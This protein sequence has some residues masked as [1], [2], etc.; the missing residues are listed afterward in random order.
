MGLKERIDALE[1]DVL[2]ESAPK[3]SLYPLFKTA[4]LITGK[5]GLLPQSTINNFYLTTYN[6][7]VDTPLRIDPQSVDMTRLE[8]NNT[9]NLRCPMCDTQSSIRK[10]IN[11]T[12][13]HLDKIIRM[14]RDR[15]PGVQKIFSFHTVGEPI[16]S[17]MFEDYLKILDRYNQKL[18]LSTNGI[19]IDRKLDLLCKYSHLIDTIR[20]SIDGATKETYERMRWP[21]KFPKLIENLELFTK[22]NKGNKYFKKVKIGSVICKTTKDEIAHHLD[23]YQKYVP[24]KNIKFSFLTS[25]SPTKEF[26][27]DDVILEKHIRLN[28]PC[29]AIFGSEHHVLANGDVSPCSRDYNGEITV[30]NVF[31]EDFDSIVNS[32]RSVKLREEQLAGGALE[33]SLC[34]TC[35]EIDG[36]IP[37]LFDYL[38]HAI[39]LQ[40]SYN[41][42]SVSRAQEKF[43]RFLEICEKGFPTSNEYVTLFD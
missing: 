26:F 7:K 29:S 21:A 33:G 35:Y 28:N 4:R 2:G 16:V 12:T 8:T 20:F 1:S 30:G 22:A 38:L 36:R 24:L 15:E 39:K 17:P 3:R 23:F 14:A 9:C 6:T 34:A 40:Y 10:K 43:D 18:D 11:I 27:E 5:T 37:K 31:D 32:S 19:L 41:K 13:E 42:L 25:L